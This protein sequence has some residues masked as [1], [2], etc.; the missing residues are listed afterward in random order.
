MQGGPFRRGAVAN[1]PA[2]LTDIA[3]TVLHLLGLESQEMEGRPLLGAF[4]AAAD[5]V[6][7]DELHDMPGGF[8]LEVMRAVGGRLYPT[9]LRRAR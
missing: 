9:A 5:A 4:D 8:V 1:E 7:V 6:P 2:D 3:P